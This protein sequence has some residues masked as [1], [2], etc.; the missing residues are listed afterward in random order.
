MKSLQE[1]AH[2]VSG[3]ILDVYDLN[4]IVLSVTEYYNIE[5]L[6]IFLNFKF[7]VLDDTNLKYIKI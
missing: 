7:H 6:Q 3:Y 2:T 5:N 1:L 4:N